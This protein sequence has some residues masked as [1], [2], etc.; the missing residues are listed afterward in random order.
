MLQSFLFQNFNINK[1]MKFL[2]KSEVID[3]TFLFNL[4]QETIL[5]LHGWGGNKNS[6]ASTINLLKHHYNLLSIT[7]PTTQPTQEVWN[8]FDYK[9]LILNILYLHN[10]KE[11]SIICHSFGFRVASVLNGFIKINKIAITGGAGPKKFSIFNKITQQNNKILLKNAKFSYIYKKIASKDYITLS[12][13][14]KSSFKNIVNLNT[15][16]LI[17]F[18]CP[19]LLFWGKRD[20]ATPIWIAKKIKKENQSKLVVTNSG[21]F[22]YLEDNSLFN[23]LV[24]GFLK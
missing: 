20:R 15:L 22:A 11:V 13:T 6:F 2:Y 23:N 12:N 17:N 24:I 1:N 14:N 19:I 21:H 3:Y 10:V 7:M 9:N 8:L 16:T 5:F 18:N 4:K